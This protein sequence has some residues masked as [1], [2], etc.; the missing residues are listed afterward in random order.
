MSY[1]C[2]MERDGD[3]PPPQ[4]PPG[5]DANDANALPFPD[6]LCHRCAAPPQYIRTARSTFIRCPILKR[7]PPQPV[8]RCEEFVPKDAIDGS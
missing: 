8:V 6:S 3:S 4:G 5:R 7:Y 2:R 1:L